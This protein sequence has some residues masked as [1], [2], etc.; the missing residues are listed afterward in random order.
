MGG[1]LQSSPNSVGSTLMTCSCLSL[2]SSLANLLL[3]TTPSE[4]ISPLLHR[5]DSQF[6]FHRCVSQLHFV[7]GLLKCLLSTRISTTLPTVLPRSTSAEH[8]PERWW[9][10]RWVRAGLIRRLR[11]RTSS[12]TPLGVGKVVDR[13]SGWC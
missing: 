7:D 4:C 8:V 12:K 9:R 3:P 5:C 1:I 2:P 11:P 10:R 13:L 6:T